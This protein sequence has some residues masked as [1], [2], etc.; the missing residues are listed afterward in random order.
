M[1][2]PE[3]HRRTQFDD[4][5]VRTIRTGQHSMLAQTVDD[6]FSPSLI[7]L[8]NKQWENQ[9][10]IFVPTAPDIEVAIEETRSILGKLW[11]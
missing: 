10:R 2:A 3:H 11:K 9:L 5:V 7:D 1:L 8:A 6:F 4:I